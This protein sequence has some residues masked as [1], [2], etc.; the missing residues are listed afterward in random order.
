L[1]YNLKLILKRQKNKIKG[2]KRKDYLTY[3]LVD[4]L[5]LFNL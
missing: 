2:N 5:F 1:K 3:F 4:N